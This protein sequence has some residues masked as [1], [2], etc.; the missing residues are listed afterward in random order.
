MIKR[1]RFDAMLTRSSAAYR[2]RLGFRADGF[3][4]RVRLWHLIVTAANDHAED[5]RQQD[6]DGQPKCDADPHP[7]DRAHFNS[8]FLWLTALT[9]CALRKVAI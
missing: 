8:P 5:E 1:F 4:L 2:L 3:V 9:G 7:R 6:S